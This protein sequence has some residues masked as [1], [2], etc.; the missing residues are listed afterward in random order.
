M[1][2]GENAMAEPYVISLGTMLVE[3]MRIQLDE[4]LYQPGTFVGPFPSGD[5]PVYV[6][7]V[8]KLGHRSG[9]IGA[10]GQDD[11]GRCI[12][13]RFAEHQVDARYVRVLNDRTTGVAF[14]SYASDG[15]RKF[16]F[17]WRN[18]AA[19]QIA[20]DYVSKEYLANAKWLHIT[21]G[22]LVITDASYQACLRALQYLS[23]QAIVSFDPNI[24]AE[25]LNAEEI[26]HQWKPFLERADYILPSDGEAMLI[27]GAPSDEEGCKQ[28]AAAGK[29]VLL[30][31]G[32]AGSVVFAPNQEFEVPGFSVPEVDPT[33]AGDTFCAGFTVAILNGLPL[34]QAAIFAN[35]VGALAVTRKGPMEG[36]PTR[37]QAEELIASLQGV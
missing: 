6:N 15:S 21:G 10:V 37:A 33:G 18:A 23:S 31:R 35:A 11:F 19:G 20:P 28:L 1:Q 24:R 3:I 13:D 4:P 14:V 8:A 26:R 22:N 36:A 34:R 27:T 17:H 12:L 7:A 16:I 29:T 25:W 30:K 9:F 32:A 5:T 2:Q